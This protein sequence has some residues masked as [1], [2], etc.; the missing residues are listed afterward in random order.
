MERLL[1]PPLSEGCPWSGFTPPN[2]DWCEENLCA[3]VVN[4]ADTW[5][6][7]AY[8]AAGLWMLHAAR[9]R[10]A[11]GL[12]FF[13]PAA[14]AVGLCSG[15]YHASYTYA[16][17]LLD[18]LGMYLFCFLVLV[19]NARRLRWIDEGAQARWY[20]GGVAALSAATPLLFET[21]LPIQGLVF[22]LILAGVG[23]EIALAR[24]A[25]GRA[26]A[27]APFAAAL[28]L[29]T[30]AAVFSALDVTRT[31]C[32]PDD[33]WIQGHALWHVLSAAALVALFYFYAGFGSK[34]RA[35]A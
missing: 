6:N 19:L 33:H 16:L 1:A 32:D 7:L 35:D 17:Q 15:I 5:S 22:V 28:A 12:G 31:W 11:P 26:P 14:I 29:L 13:G 27:Y 3:W 9:G 10:N 30:G 18:F 23:Q 34:P 4:P 21:G 8:L 24:R 20:L 25:D 2:V